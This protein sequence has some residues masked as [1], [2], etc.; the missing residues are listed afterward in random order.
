[1]DTGDGICTIR[2][3]PPQ[4]AA[5]LKSSA[6]IPSLASV[7]LGLV[8][9]SLDANARKVNVSVDFSRGAASVED[10]GMGIPPKEFGDSGG[11]GRP[12]RRNLNTISISKSLTAFRYLQIQMLKRYSWT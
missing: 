1:M 11:L 8:A 12:H 7:V 4:V 2:P 9:N 10:D 3:L 6:A 5:Q